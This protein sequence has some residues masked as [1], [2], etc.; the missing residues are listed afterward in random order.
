MATRIKPSPNN[1]QKIQL[2]RIS[3]V[4]LRHVDPEKFLTFAKDFGF[5]EEARD[6]DSV[7]LR[8]YGEDPYCYVVQPSTTGE[9]QFDGGAFLVKSK[10]DLEKA[11]KFPGATRKDLT[12]LPGGG[13]LVS[14]TAPGGG[15]IHLI[16]G[17]KPRAV[18]EKEPSAQVQH[19]GPYNLPFTKDRKGKLFKQQL[20]LHELTSEKE[21]FNVSKLLPP[22]CTSSATM[23]T[24]LTLLTKILPFTSTTSTSHLPISFLKQQCLTS[25]SSHSF[26]SILAPS[27]LI[28]TLY[29][30]SELLQGRR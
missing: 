5:V 3:H 30:C 15:K 7:Y 18:P 16:W 9:K 12:H 6:G 1:P 4:F 8:G 20:K 23:A 19:L 28:T 14:L 27:S 13:E 22:W 21:S 2:Q 24:S 29:S 10:E 25:M 26:T 17:Q 11:M